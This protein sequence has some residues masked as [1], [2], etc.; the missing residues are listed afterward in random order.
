MPKKTY[1]KIKNYI[2]EILADMNKWNLGF[3]LENIRTNYEFPLLFTKTNY[4]ESV[5]NTIK[6]YTMIK[7]HSYSWNYI[8]K[9]I[10][11]LINRH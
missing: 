4:C 3:L 6:N 8:V 11:F 5:N 10:I 7:K 9:K 2:L 1:K